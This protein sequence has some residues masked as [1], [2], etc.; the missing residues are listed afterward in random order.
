MTIEIVKGSSAPLGEEGGVASSPSGFSVPCLSLSGR[1]AAVRRFTS[2]IFT[3][4]LLVNSDLFACFVLRRVSRSGALLFDLS[5]IFDRPILELL[6]KDAIVCFHSTE[7]ESGF[8]GVLASRIGYGFLPK[9][10]QCA[11][12]TR[13]I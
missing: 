1:K 10:F 5:I 9:S 8:G 7:M 11:L 6:T 12:P 3:G 4:G 2:F 13:T